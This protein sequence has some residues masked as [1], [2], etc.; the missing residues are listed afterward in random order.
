MLEIKMKLTSYEQQILERM[1]TGWS[2]IDAHEKVK[3]KFIFLRQDTNVPI[4][5]WQL[6]PRA[7]LDHLVELKLVIG[8]E[9]I[10]HPGLDMITP[11]VLKGECS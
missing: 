9:A 7:T 2:L 4:T 8:K 3:P 6:V 5:N 11:Y 1:K 10:A